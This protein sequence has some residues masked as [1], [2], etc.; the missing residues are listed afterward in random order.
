MATQLPL[1]RQN[2]G[3]I[4]TL[5]ES[6]LLGGTCLNY[7]CI[8]TKTLKS[9]AEAFETV[10]HAQDF[11]ITTEGSFKIDMPAVISRKNRVSDTL[12]GGLEKTCAQ[13]K[14]NVIYGV[15][16][17]VSASLVEVTRNDGTVEKVESDSVIIAT[18]SSTLNLPSLPVDH[19]F[20]LS[21]DDALELDHVPSSLIIV[22][23]G[24]I[25][26]ELAFTYQALGSKVTLVEGPDRV[27]LIPS[28]DEEMSKIF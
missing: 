16:K 20:I 28:V 19:K 3:H 4:V 8:P 26:C 6:K 11:G 9:S 25:D 23:G 14:V 22:G 13:L 17:V 7:G 18:G 2:T 21:S 1:M 27:L 24:V 12:R 15:G 5:I 10:C